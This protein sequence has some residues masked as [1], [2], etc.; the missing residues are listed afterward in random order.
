MNLFWKNLLGGITPTAKLEKSEND[1]VLAMK[2]Y[3][4]VEKSVELVEYKKLFNTVKSAE[5]QENKKILQN[6]NYKDTQEFQASNKYKKLHNLPALNLYYEVLKSEELKQYLAFKS[7]SEYKNLGDPKKVKELAILQKMKAFEKSKNFKTYTRFHDSYILKEY[8]QLKVKIEN[9]E[10]KKANAF[11]A[12][13][14]RWHTTPEFVHQER[15]Y[16]LAKNPDIVFFEKEKPERFEKQRKQ[17]LTFKDE[18]DWNTLDKSRWNFGF[19]Y[20]NQNL[21]GNHSFTNEKQANNSGK[22]V[23]VA[24]GILKLLTKVEKVTAKA[25]HPQKGFVEKEYQFTSDI[26]QTADSFKQKYGTIRAKI[27]CTGDVHHAFWLGGDGKLPHINIFHFN[28][29]QITVGNANNNVFDGVKVSG[30]NPAQYYIYTL[31]WTK[32]ELIWLINDIEIYRTASN[33]P[34]QEMY[35]AFNSFIS[36]KQSGSAG[37][38]EVDWVRVYEN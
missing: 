37:S 14:K 6:R 15:F 25:W 10:F 24:D 20:K 22:N 18:F 27:R 12:N 19:H 32:K 13:E 34:N 8:E 26:L 31:V 5:F 7:T 35:L 1:L 38:I 28:G 36:E 33:V 29:K 9:P 3:A 4:E 30:L 17:K 2:R 23:A 16:E 11:W 21:I